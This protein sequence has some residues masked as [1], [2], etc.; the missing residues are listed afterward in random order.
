MRALGQQARNMARHPWARARK[1]HSLYIG[2]GTPTTV[3]MFAMG[4]FIAACL[5]GFDFTAV[6]S[7]SPEITMEANPNTVN[8][9]ML[10]RSI[11]AGVNRLSIGAQ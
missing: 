11:E 1:F 3:D 4:D 10:E 7:R 8:M 9:A 6:S 2:G 5:D